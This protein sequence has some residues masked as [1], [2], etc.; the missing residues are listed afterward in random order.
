MLSSD[1]SN[2]AVSDRSGTHL[3]LVMMKAHRALSR[4]ADR[5]IGFTELG[6]TDFIV[7]ELLLHRGPQPVNEIGRRFGLSSGAC[8]AA[9]DRL[10]AAGLVKRA[11]HATDRRA[12]IV[13][14]TPAG[15]R[16]AEQAFAV[17]KTTMD[18]AGTALTEAE[19]ATL[20]RLLKKLGTV[21]ELQSN[22]AKPKE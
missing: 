19:R 14:L 18:E 10:E 22:E 2:K 21:V 17:H 12:R 6:S 9:V 13:Q 3:W 20:I 11:S 5:S 8:T 15:S 4:L 16:K 1:P 7:M